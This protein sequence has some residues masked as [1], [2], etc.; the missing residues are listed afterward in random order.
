MTVYY[1]TKDFICVAA[2][3][4]KPENVSLIVPVPLFWQS[5]SILCLRIPQVKLSGINKY[6]FGYSEWL[7]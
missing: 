5:F 1:L 7:P 3:D 4:N 6:T 2:R